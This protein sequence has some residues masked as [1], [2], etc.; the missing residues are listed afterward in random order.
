[1]VDKF[2]EWLKNV[3]PP[4]PDVSGERQEFISALYEKALKQQKRRRRIKIALSV[5]C[6]VCIVAVIGGVQQVGSDGGETVFEKIGYAGA[7][8]YKTVFG[9]TRFAV[10][11]TVT[12]DDWEELNARRIT[13]DQTFVEAELYQVAGQI[14]YI[15]TFE[16]DLDGKEVTVSHT[17]QA[18]V[19]SGTK[20]TAIFIAQYYERIQEIIQSGQAKRLPTETVVLDGIPIVFQRWELEFPQ[21]GRVVYGKGV[22]E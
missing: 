11:D 6:V 14:T 4:T 7:A 22:R 13:G 9:D 10:T 15:L 21:Y 2:R 8:L 5:S 20:E 16:Y 1:M 19:G 17:P 12:Q 18:S 3:V